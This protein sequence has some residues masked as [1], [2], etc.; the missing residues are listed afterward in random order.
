MTANSKK[1]FAKSAAKKPPQQYVEV[2]IPA[3]REFDGL[4]CYEDGMAGK[5]R[6][7]SNSYLEA[8]YSYD[9]PAYTL[10][11]KKPEEQE[12][13]V[14]KI[15]PKGQ[16]A[17]IVFPEQKFYDFEAI[18]RAGMRGDLRWKSTE[19]IENAYSITVPEKH[20]SVKNEPSVIK[21]ALKGP[22]P[23]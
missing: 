3:H 23:K 13:Y 15:S 7:A 6:N 1:S 19:M 16:R 10:Q 8:V 12:P 11:L 4:S 20:L 18:K 17:T 22:A 5:L 2:T 21:A 9:V 14:G